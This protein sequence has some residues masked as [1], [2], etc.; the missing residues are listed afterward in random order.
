MTIALVEV[1]VEPDGYRK[2]VVVELEGPEEPITFAGPR[3]AYCGPVRAARMVQ[4]LTTRVQELLAQDKS[5]SAEEVRMVASDALAEASKAWAKEYRAM[6]MPMA[7]SCSTKWMG[8]LPKEELTRKGFVH[9]E[10]EPRPWSDHIRTLIDHVDK[11]Y[12]RS[13]RV[14][15]HGN[16][17]GQYAPCRS[18][19]LYDSYSSSSAEGGRP[20]L[21]NGDVLLPEG[22]P[23]EAF[24]ALM[25]QATDVIGVETPGRPMVEVLCSTGA[26]AARP[27]RLAD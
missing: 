1:R 24:R 20:Q 23:A 8:Q 16:V 25:A 9:F 19:L 22:G 11:V 14:K 26:A 4:L 21:K 12:P 3:A 2:L 17:N 10:E 5:A 15:T 6:T 13:S 27:Q 18:A 7:Y